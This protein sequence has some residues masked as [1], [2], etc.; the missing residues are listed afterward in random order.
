M[1]QI[2]LNDGSYAIVDDDD[3]ERLAQYRWTNTQGYA[4]RDVDRKRVFM[5]RLVLVT[6][7]GT[8]PDHINRNPLDNRKSN[9]RAVTRTQN[10]MNRGAVANTS[11]RFKGVSWNRAANKWSAQIR[12]NYRS[13]YLGL[14]RDEIVAALAY[15]IA[16][17]L[18][19]GEYAFLNFPIV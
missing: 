14:F 2:P 18:L 13:I 10:S 15:D 12:C 7:D 4:T 3:Y 19:F 8:E 6:S 16:A 1:A 17:Y 5:H 9:L 11:S